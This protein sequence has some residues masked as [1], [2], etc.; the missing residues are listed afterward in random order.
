MEKLCRAYWL[1]LYSHI[2]RKGYSPADSQDLT[3][4]FFSR[5]V[6]EGAFDSATRGNGSFRSYL[7]ASLNHL[8]AN[9][10][11]KAQTLKRGG[12]HEIISLDAQEAEGRFMHEA[13][14]DDPP[15]KAFDRQWALTV[16][17][18]ALLRVR[19]QFNSAG[20][21]AHFESLKGFLSNVAG[22]GDYA[23]LAASLGLDAGGVAVAGHR[24]RLRYRDM[25][26]AEIAQTVATEAELEA[27]MRHLFS[28]L[29]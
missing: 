19:E 21:L 25:V 4:E 2:R 13:V 27:E 15:E 22:E 29:D 20:K 26:R 23:S 9:E 17:D 5:L 18:R 12:G 1:P 10:W 24:L 11:H 7:L 16:L 6:R 28:S 14:T 3:Q 8:L